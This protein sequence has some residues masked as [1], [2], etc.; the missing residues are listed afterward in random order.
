MISSDAHNITLPL[1]L[2]L[3]NM[4]ADKKDGLCSV[5]RAYYVIADGVGNGLC[6]WAKYS[7]YQHG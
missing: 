4:V 6:L 2:A 3:F 1:V 5:F 7:E